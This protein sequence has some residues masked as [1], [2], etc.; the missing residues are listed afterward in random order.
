MCQKILIKSSVADPIPSTG[1]FPMFANLITTESKPS[2]I[3]NKILTLDHYNAVSLGEPHCDILMIEDNSASDDRSEVQQAEQRLE[4]SS[5]TKNPPE[6]VF[7][8]L[9]LLNH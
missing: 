2:V 5:S 9:T 1:E 6:Y 4:E 8:T 3:L 7:Q